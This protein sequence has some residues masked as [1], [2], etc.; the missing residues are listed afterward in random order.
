MGALKVLPAQLANMI[1]AGEVVQRP[2]S[3]VKELMENAVDAQ[4][5][6]VSVIIVDAGRTLIQVIDDGCGMSPSDAVLCFERHATSKISEAEDL[7]SILTYGFRGEALASIAAVSEVSLK[8]RR[9]KDSTGVEVKLGLSGQT[10]TASVACPKG[11]NFQVRNLFC[12]T[13]ARR[14]FLKSDNVELKHIIEEFTRVALT[15]PEI[16]FS[17]NSNGRDLF[18][19]KPAKSLKFR[20]LDL[21][22]GNVV[23]DLVDIGT[24]TSLVKIHGYI[25]RPQAARKT[26]GNQFFFVNG[27]YFRSPYLHKAVMS[28]YEE[29]VP[30]GL[31]PTYFIFLEMDP[32]SVDINI[33]P[34]KTE[35]KF[36]DD[37]LLF[38]V[39]M[40]SVRETLGRNSFGA[41]LDF[42]AGPQLPQL[43]GSFEEYRGPVSMPEHELDPSYNPFD[44]SPSGGFESRGSYR[45]IDCSPSADF[46]ASRPSAGGSQG[47]YATR[48]FVAPSQDYGKLFEQEG[49]SARRT[50]MVV[51]RYIVTP[52]ASGMMLVNIRRARQRILY[53]QTLRSL[54]DEVVTT[55]ALLFT[56]PVQVGVQGAL[57]F[58]QNAALLE[59][60]GFQLSIE[61][62]CVTISGVPQ[63]FSD[64]CTDPARLVEDLSAILSESGAFLPELMKQRMAEKIAFAGCSGPEKPSSQLEAQQLIDTLFACDNAEFTSDGHKIVSIITLDELDKRF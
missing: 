17:L 37:S 25:G 18:Q 53:E 10:K 35:V 44:S 62:D 29:M 23:G 32:Q 14:K 5:T 30:D 28:A 46:A 4:S 31:T 16:A 42:E 11:S 45:G 2:S 3:V 58:E 57:L 7:N 34:T 40:A 63:G 38:Q 64:S 21:L 15:R 43:G 41:S 56:S 12:N 8:T 48:G 60:I 6:K 33:H 22:G 13:P 20:L 27:R 47:S 51:G 54:S 49:L 52:V 9:E 55:Q 61:G 1:A 39:L 59:R 24:E 26:L 36:E 19:L 50:M